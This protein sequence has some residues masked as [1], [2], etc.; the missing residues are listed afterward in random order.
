LANP[1]EADHEYGIRLA[2]WSEMYDLDAL[3]VAVPHRKY[4]EQP[5]AELLTCLKPDG[6]L[7]D[8]KSVLNPSDLPASITYWSL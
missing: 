4:L 5:L 3:I 7:M 2:D 8:I 1:Q 6:V